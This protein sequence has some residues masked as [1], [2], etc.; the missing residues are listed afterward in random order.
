M[1]YD[2][3]AWDPTHLGVK[4]KSNDGKVVSFIGIRVP[5]FEVAFPEGGGGTTFTNGLL[6]CGELK[7]GFGRVNM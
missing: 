1:I 7:E 4:F 2:R 5:N 3:Y 6:A